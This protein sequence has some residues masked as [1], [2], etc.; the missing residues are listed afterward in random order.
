MRIIL[1]A[2][3]SLCGPACAKV[4]LRINDAPA[5]VLAASDLAKLPRH[6]AVLDDHG[7]QVS[8]EGALLRDLLAQNGVSFE[9]GLHGKQL[10]SYVA[11]VASDGYEVVFALGDFDPTIMDSDILMAD[12]REGRALDSKEGPLRIVVPHDK[13]PARSLRML[14]E[15]DVVQLRK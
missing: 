13:R 15:I 7:K 14:Q 2:L 1:L 8:Y 9:K 12:K 3:V 5:V 4:T 11:A 10:A 6:T